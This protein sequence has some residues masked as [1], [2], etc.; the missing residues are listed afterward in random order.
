MAWLH[1]AQDSGKWPAV[2]TTVMNL[3]VPRNAE[4]SLTSWETAG[5]TR[6]HAITH[7]PHVPPLERNQAPP[8]QHIKLYPYWKYA[9]LSL[10]AD[11]LATKFHADGICHFDNTTS[12]RVQ[13]RFQY[14]GWWHH[15]WQ[16]TAMVTPHV[17][18]KL[19][20][21]HTWQIT[22]MVTTHV[23]SNSYGDTTRD[24]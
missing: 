2:A 1:L 9:T 11:W 7:T 6:R 19:W 3:L 10:S 17:E 22:A 13:S 12:K 5:F 15:T 16:I 14:R 8:T 4:N 21:Q 20:W 23:T 24:K 18:S